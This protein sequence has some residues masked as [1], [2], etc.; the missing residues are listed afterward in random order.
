MNEGYIQVGVHPNPFGFIATL[1]RRYRENKHVGWIYVMRNP[2]FREELLKIGKSRRPP[3]ERAAELGSA[4]AVPEGFQLIYFIHA[5]DHHQAEK[6]VHR[7]LTA[8]RKS[9]SKEF[10][11]VPL[12][13]ALEALDRAAAA[14]PIL[15]RKRP[16][17]ALPQCFG[18]TAVACPNCGVRQRVR[19]LA[20]AVVVKC[21]ACGGNILP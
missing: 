6:M 12:R 16:L 1:D 21:A 15:M 2:A 20:V 9:A 13:T 5:S 3:M 17:V 10:F 18:A 8:Y 19:Q 4:T 11:D 14:Y 7:E